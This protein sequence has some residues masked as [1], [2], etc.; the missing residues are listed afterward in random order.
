MKP[1]NGDFSSA[2]I[3]AGM[4]RHDELMCMPGL[5]RVV[6]CCDDQWTRGTGC[7]DAVV[8]DFGNLVRVSK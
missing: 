1:S 8:D 6:L 2:S 5:W 7:V 4:Y 3:L